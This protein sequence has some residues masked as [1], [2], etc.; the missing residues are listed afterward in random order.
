MLPLENNSAVIDTA[1][2]FGVL[3]SAEWYFSL[4]DCATFFARRAKNVEQ[5][6]VDV[7]PQLVQ[8]Y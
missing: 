7:C 6:D 4:F 1:H 5:E 3:P 8:A 2:V